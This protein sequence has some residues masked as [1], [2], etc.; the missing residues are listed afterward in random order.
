MASRFSTVTNPHEH[1][2]IICHEDYDANHE[3]PLRLPCLHIVDEKC[4]RLWL[5]Q[6]NECPICRTLMVVPKS[7]PALHPVLR[8]RSGMSTSES[9]RRL[10]S[11]DRQ[12][13][14]RSSSSRQSRSAI[15]SRRFEH[16]SP[17]SARHG[18]TISSSSHYGISGLSSSHYQSSHASPLAYGSSSSL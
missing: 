13:L 18:L 11:K 1:Q 7:E 4:L 15:S 10:A 17:S 5:Q 14:F 12:S 16:S 8:S 6:S 3:K 2:C 9:L